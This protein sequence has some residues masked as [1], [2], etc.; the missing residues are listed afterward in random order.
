MSKI[1]LTYKN[2]NYELEYTRQAVK[3]MEAQGF[4]LDQVSDKPMTMIPLLIYGA[5]MKN[6]ASVK[7]KTI[8]EIA[9]ELGNNKIKFI[10]ALAEMYA[11]TVSSLMG[12]D[13]EDAEGNV[14]W[15]VTQ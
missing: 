5:F 4:V 6:H 13:D 12:E 14:Q 11:E 10:N 7:R 3:N 9:D 15:E 1:N 8:D 2:K